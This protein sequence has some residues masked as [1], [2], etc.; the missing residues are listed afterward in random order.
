MTLT[1]EPVNQS[2]VRQVQRALGEK[3]Q[4]ARFAQVLYGQESFK[5]TA[6]ATSDW[7][8][9]N[10]RAAC[11]FIVEKS[12]KK[13]K[14]RIRSGPTPPDGADGT[15]IEIL[16][17]DMP[18]LVDSVI[19]ELQARSLAVRFLLHPIF[20]V[21]R[22]KM[23]RLQMLIGPGD[24]NWNDGRQ[25]SY[26]AVYLQPLPESVRRD[27]AKSLLDVLVAVRQVVDDWQQ[28]LRHVQAAI[29][30]LES[31]PPQV[32][33]GE[34]HEAIAFLRWLEAGNFTFLGAREYQFAGHSQTGDL[35]PVQ[36]AG[37][38]VLRDPQVHVLRRGTELVDL[39]PEIRRFYAAPAPLII[40]KASVVSRVHRRVHMDYIGIKTYRRD[41]TLNGEVRVVGLFTSQAYVRSPREIPFVRRK[42]ETVQ[43][44]SAYPVASHAG[45]ALMNVL[46]TFP[47]DELFQIEPEQLREWSE[48]ILDLETRPRVRVLARV[49]RFDRF[50]SVLVYVPRDRYGSAVRERIGVL[51]A[52]AYR[53]RIAAFYPFFTDGPLVRVQFIVG[54]YDGPT[55]EVDVAQL[56]RGIV[57]ML[58]TWNDRL[59]DALAGD[60]PRGE[61]LLAKY[62][63][64]FSAGYAESFTVGR[65]LEDIARIERLERGLPV[66]IDFYREADAPLH[67][68]RAAIYRY[69]GP[70]KLSQRV[71]LLENMGFVAID[72]R[73][74][75][76]FPRDAEGPREVTLHDMVL[77]TADAAPLD[78]GRHDKRLEEAFLATFHGVADNDSFN[79]LVIAAGADWRNVATLRAY[80]AFLRQ[81]GSPFGLRYIADTLF[82]HAGVTRDL[83]ELFHVRFDPGRKL[84]LEDRAAAEAPLRK[85]I[86]DALAAV[87]SL[88]EDRILRQFL[89]VV[90]ATVR[91]NF[92][93]TRPDG[94]PPETIAF[95]L[96]SNAVDLAPR[97]RPYREIWVY[98]P[99]V[100]GVHLRFAPIARGGIRWSDRAQDFRTEVL[101]LV[102]A[103]VVK[104][105]VIVPS[106]AK[107]GFLPKQLPRSGSRDEMQKEGVAAYRIFISALLDI[108][109]NL[110]D[111]KVVHPPL[112]VRHDSDDPYLVVAADKGTATFSDIANEIS[113]AHDFWLGDAFAS[114]GSV[115]Y[116]HKGMGI[117]ARGAW[118]C[119]KR[120]FREMDVDVQAQP[121]RV[122]GVGD[123]SGDVFGN[124]MLMSDH[125]Q[126]VAAFDHRDI[127][128]DPNPRADSILERRRLFNLPRSSWQDYDQAKISKGGGVFS[129]SSKSI[130][131]SE[132]MK[133]LLDLSAATITPAELVRAV[134]R[135]RVDLLWFG[136]I[137]TFVRASAERDEDVGDRANDP[138]RA[139]AAEIR[140]KVI[141]E[142]ANLGVTQRG[143]VEFAA[144]GGRINTD[145]IDNSAGVN[146]S[147]QEVNIKIAVAPAVRAGKLASDARRKLLSGMTEEVAAASLRNNYQ[148]SL[149]LSLAAMR[150]VRDL[151]DYVLLIRALEDRGLLVRDL[152]ALPSDTELQERAR[153]GL[154][155]TRPELA[156]LLSYAKIALQHD[157]LRSKVPDEPRLEGWL[158]GYFPAKLRESFAAGISS[159]SLRREIVALGLT[160]AVV[161]RGGPAMAARIAFEARRSAS[162]VAAAF[163][164]AREVFDLPA[165]W[166]RIDEL[167]ARTQGSAQLRLYAATQDLVREQTRW[168]LRDGAAADDLAGMIDRHKLGLAALKT[169]LEDI[170]PP[171][172]KVRLERRAG[173]LC[174]GGIPAHLAADVAALDVLAQ[175]PAITGISQAM[176]APIP[177]TG[178]TFLEI[179]EHLRI[180]D[181]IT[182]GSAI[183]VQDQY[184]RLAVSQAI[185]QLSA[186]QAVFT[187]AAI[188]A[189]GSEAW[190]SGQPDRL[191]RV[192]STLDELAGDD[193]LSVS[194]LV[195]AAG[196]LSELAA[197][198]VSP[199]ASARRARRRDRSGHATSGSR[200]A[201][202]P[203]RQARS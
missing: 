154:G 138:L 200:P 45:K 109:D 58:R 105:A 172:C 182:K 188:A 155:L 197:G 62:R 99:R 183:P 61:L 33:E 178:R 123:M 108:T 86:E 31:G 83:L 149:A 97:P 80:A 114:G 174:E 41:G 59:A 181:L 179:G 159:H 32:P 35:V 13:P 24:Q 85:R 176:G 146:T 92:F 134:L 112:V 4:A 121:I 39:T 126:L 53:G 52:E 7:L 65:A 66:A 28:M 147:D 170:V 198:S 137:G 6:A 144:R 169:A 202:K 124:G 140:A 177:D 94:K 75:Q 127:F 15:V 2:L 55:P 3:T 68:I 160:N 167:D 77:E 56:E 165:L 27:L 190:R 148:Q 116:D 49:D 135:C 141:G 101:G 43:Q 199:S 51:L 50:V 82:R 153:T 158:A 46:E 23:G 79:R 175:S 78:L 163:A 98:S 150:S 76:I 196:R 104:N 38:G 151:P 128:I 143:R 110:K 193:M 201:R 145:F 187:R 44:T 9:A 184:D 89:S 156:V 37:L 36:R 142:G 5:D 73:S 16:N 22:D 113:A 25:E 203:A 133:A 47:R 91:T 60:G 180:A 67:R 1:T 122:A 21:E 186:A 119:V 195:V 125:I 71:P 168:F 189:G 63:T 132:E 34:L 102:R 26:I 18:F 14:L 95:K 129:R 40:T 72:E 19:G 103:Q 88:D 171:R 139:S 111:G 194:R 70:I 69:G 106:G 162:D 115:G 11:D 192:Q 107:G 130:A 20:K 84:A 136:G 173:E 93:Q 157:I 87:P 12:R 90:G 42:V 131:V 64:A 10:A 117:T 17:D 120:H 81:L 96:D 164:V 48:A 152:E 166:K 100:E 30:H 191:A 74:Y 57:E 118:E 8:A 54:R 29:S 185:G 161:N